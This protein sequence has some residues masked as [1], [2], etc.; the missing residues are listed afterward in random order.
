MC[1]ALG[2]RKLGKIMKEVGHKGMGSL[3][4]ICLPTGNEIS[5]PRNDIRP[6]GRRAACFLFGFT[7]LRLP[8]RHP[9]HHLS[10]YFA[11]LFLLPTEKFVPSDL[12]ERSTEAWNFITRSHS[13][14]RARLIPRVGACKLLQLERVR[15]ARIDC[16]ARIELRFAPFDVG[17]SSSSFEKSFEHRCPRFRLFKSCRLSH[18]FFFFFLPTGERFVFVSLTLVLSIGWK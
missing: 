11:I 12:S 17:R 4:T 18:F 7:F 1:V 14:C 16:G 10:S 9:S 15:F 6:A 13:S 2:R 5:R 3:G 8:H